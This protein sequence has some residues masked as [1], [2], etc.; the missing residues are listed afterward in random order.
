M[1]GI[2]R[3]LACAVLFALAALPARADLFEAEH[4]TLANGLEVV[5]LPK[6]LAPVVYQMV[7][8]RVG[9]ADGLPG[10]NGIA[11]FLEH[12]MFKATGK[13]AAG[14]FSK[15]VDRVGGSDNAYTGQDVTAYHQEF[16]REHL[17]DIM[18][19]EADR[20]VNLR[21]DDSVVLPE[22]DVI[23][24]ERGQ[25]T[26]NNPGA[27]LAEAVNAAIYRNHPY[28]NP[29][30]GWRHEI[31]TYSTADALD[32]YRRWYAPNNAILIVAGDVT[33]DEVLQLAE[34]HFGAIP[35]RALPERARL[36]EPPAVAVRRLSLQSPEVRYP[37][38]SRSYL[39]PSYRTAAKTQTAY[40]L[41]VLGEILDGGLVGRLHRRLVVEQ[42]V[43]ISAGASYSGDARDYG[44]FGFYVSPR[45]AGDLAAAEAAMDAEIR[46]LLVDGV[47]ALEVAQAKERLRISSVKA[48]DSLSGPARLV[49]DALGADL[50]LAELQAWPERIAAVTAEEV[51]LA[52]RSIL[53]PQNGVTAILTPPDATENPAPPSGGEETP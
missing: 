43:A 22:R 38:V 6:H 27:R 8:Y 33:A 3:L 18:A 29:V 32:F 51:M 45:E 4:F 14:A 30:I 1:T 46:R 41:S 10:K 40:A 48:R 50:S 19:M 20:M 31:E 5:V 28:G 42:Q 24:N 17:A 35:R 16:A 26:E 47:T 49:A 21:L 13:L 15:E 36:G 25:Q 37:S 7:V 34:R 39:A 2:A 52:A 12:L 23:L 11:H 53:T 9:A 44:R